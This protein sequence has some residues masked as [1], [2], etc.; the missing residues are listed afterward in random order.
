M[1]PG[2]D[3][4]FCSLTLVFHRNKKRYIKS[5]SAAKIYP[6]T[7]I[8]NTHKNETVWRYLALFSLR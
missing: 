5:V 6:F 8:N 2:K 1:P 3:L 7:G 4:L